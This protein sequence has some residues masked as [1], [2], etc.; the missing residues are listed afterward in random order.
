M[1]GITAHG[2]SCLNKLYSTKLCGGFK[3][4]ISHYKDSYLTGGTLYIRQSVQIELQLT[5]KLQ[6]LKNGIFIVL[7]QFL[8]YKYG[9]YL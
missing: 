7:M 9:V 1:C 6:K 8:C 5:I 2:R 4:C 3:I